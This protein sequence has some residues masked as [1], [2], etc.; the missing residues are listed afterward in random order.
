MLYITYCAKLENNL[1]KYYMENNLL[2]TTKHKECVHVFRER[3]LRCIYSSVLSEIVSK[4][5]DGQI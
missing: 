3:A 5:I 1:K 4:L 2:Y